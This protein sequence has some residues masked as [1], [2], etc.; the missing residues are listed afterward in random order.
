M[1][2]LHVVIDVPARLHAPG[3]RFWSAAL[4]WSP[5]P[6]WDGHPELSSLQPSRGDSYVH[7]QQIHGAPRIHVDVASKDPEA[8]VTAAVAA[9]SEVRNRS[10]T[11]VFLFSPG[12]LPFCVVT[13]RPRR[14]P[15]PTTWPDGH[16]SRLVQ[17]CIDSPVARH[18]DEVAF[19][20]G[21]L[22][23]RWV[24]SSSQEFAGKWHDDAGSPLQLLFQRL[25]EPDGPVRAHL[26]LGT[27]GQPEEVRRL[28]ELG[29]VDLGAGHGGW[30]VL[31]DPVGLE[32]CV[33]TNAPDQSHHRHL[34]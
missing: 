26:D 15:E 20:R 27:D 23:G 7:L 18:E 10:Q 25:D 8:T 17:V 13:S 21:L 11:W 19:W 6:P 24:P 22:G 31:R 14:A 32:F 16:R 4:G 30:H 2:W 29:A 3:A 12:G 34:D 5:G 33:T 9:G 1:A 28:V